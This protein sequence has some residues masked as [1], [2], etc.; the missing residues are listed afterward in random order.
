VRSEQPDIEG[1]PPTALEV[2]I[3]IERSRSALRPGQLG[4]ELHMTSPNVASTLRHLESMGYVERRQDLNDGRKSYVDLTQEGKKIV[5]EIRTQRPAWL[6]EAIENTLSEKEKRQLLQ[7]GE[8]MQ[9]LAE[10]GSNR[11]SY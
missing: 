10:Y 3:T 2:L 7:A 5:A 1:I 6:R 11:R 4:A 8:V 9:R